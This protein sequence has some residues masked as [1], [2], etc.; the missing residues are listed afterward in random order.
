MREMGINR[1]GTWSYHFLRFSL[2]VIFIW[3]GVS[4]L[5]DPVSFSY[6]ID[7]YGILPEAAVRPV[8]ILLAGAEVIAAIGLLG[9]I[10]GS[11]SMIGG[12]L[13]LFMAVLAYGI[14]MGLDVDCGC[15][16]LNDPEGLAFQG[17]RQ[18]LYRDIGMLLAVFWLFFRRFRHHHKPVR[19][20]QIINKLYR[21][22]SCEG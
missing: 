3:S 11:L 18:A 4:K 13:V 2:C 22:V 8:A 5:L 9:D 6:I 10:R 7:A 17:L 12:L 15:F 21:R 14:R 19:I 1:F 16:G 20:K